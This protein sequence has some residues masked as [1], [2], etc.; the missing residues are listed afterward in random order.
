LAARI[1][2]AGST[3]D[4][5]LAVVV[6]QDLDTV[7]GVARTGQGWAQLTIEER[8]VF[9]NLAN[10]LYVEEQQEDSATFAFV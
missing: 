2:F 7:G 3:K 9:V 10:V 8:T 5:P 4:Q 1:T 6:D